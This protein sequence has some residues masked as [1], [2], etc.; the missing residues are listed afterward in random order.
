MVINNIAAERFTL[1][2]LLTACN[3]LSCSEDFLAT[4]KKNTGMQQQTMYVTVFVT[5]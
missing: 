4:E 1:Y 2:S 3:S 5:F